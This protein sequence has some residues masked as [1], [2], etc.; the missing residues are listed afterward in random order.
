[1]EIQIDIINRL[2]Q[3]HMIL[4]ARDIFSLLDFR[5]LRNCELVSKSWYFAIRNDNIWKRR[6]HREEM[7][8]PHFYQCLEKHAIFNLHMEHVSLLGCLYNKLLLAIESDQRKLKLPCN[9]I[10]KPYIYQ[11][12]EDMFL[13][14]D[15]KRIIVGENNRYSERF[16]DIYPVVVFVYDS[17]T[18]KIECILKARD[19]G[20]I[21]FMQLQG[22]L[23]FC[24]FYSNKLIYVW[25]LA[26]K[27]IVQKLQDDIPGQCVDGLFHAAHGLLISCYNVAAGSK[28]QKEIDG[29]THLIV[30]RIQSPTEMAIEKKEHLP[31]WE[32]N[33][34]ESD[35][36]YFAVSLSFGVPE[37]REIQ[38]RSKFDFQ[39]IHCIEMTP[40]YKCCSFHNGQLLIV[41]IV[42]NRIQIKF[43]EIRKSSLGLYLN[44]LKTRLSPR[45][46]LKTST[47]VFIQCGHLIISEPINGAAR[48]SYYVVE[49]QAMWNVCDVKFAHRKTFAKKF[50]HIGNGNI[51]NTRISKTMKCWIKL[52]NAAEFYRKKCI[53]LT[54]L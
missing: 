35:A 31:L 24:S 45:I 22:D 30:R 27:Q 39:I 42:S 17:F 14:M 49:V 2:V 38:I 33:Q 10:R 46:T 41:D 3:H 52:R 1:M 50:A 36:N 32:I 43:W 16:Y 4:I 28:F 44:L 20:R 51:N 34:V 47:R 29:D 23:L 37:S 40:D 19:A 8:R 26:S 11:M 53:H 21:K 9:L 6:Y 25:D 18:L 48:A 54:T 13:T 5:S 12:F 15:N 7:K